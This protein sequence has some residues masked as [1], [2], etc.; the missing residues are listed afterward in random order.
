ML[1]VQKGHGGRRSGP[2]CDSVQLV[3]LD[4]VELEQRCHQVGHAA[5]RRADVDA[6]A[7]AVRPGCPACRAGWILRAASLAVEQPDRLDEQVA[8]RHR[9]RCR[10]PRDGLRLPPCTKPRS[11]LPSL[12]QL[13]VVGRAFAGQQHHLDAAGGQR[14]LVARAELGIGALRRAGGQRHL[15]RGIRVQPPVGQ[16]QQ[17]HGQH[18]ERPGRDDQLA[19]RQQGVADRPW[20]GVSPGPRTL[21]TPP[22]PCRGR[23]ASAG[24]RW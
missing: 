4:A 7:L 5:A 19:Q 11:A 13:Q 22:L 6:Q 2:S 21:P 15:L 14:L 20:H 3:G 1:A 18:D 23:R 17:G 10:R 8:Q 16:C 12:Q 9:R 24:C